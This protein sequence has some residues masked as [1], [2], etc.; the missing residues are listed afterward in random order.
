MSGI[1]HTILRNKIYRKRE[2]VLRNRLFGYT[3]V[4]NYS[5]GAILSWIAGADTGERMP[6][7]W[8]TAVSEHGNLKRFLFIYPR[9]CFPG[10]EMCKVSL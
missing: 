8:G 1:V 3:T 7:G 5:E 10:P 2:K 4:N 6:G 9:L